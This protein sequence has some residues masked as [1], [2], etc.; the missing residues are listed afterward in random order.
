L[1]DR[2]RPSPSCFMV[3]IVGARDRSGNWDQHRVMQMVWAPPS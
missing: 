2:F 3:V 1:V